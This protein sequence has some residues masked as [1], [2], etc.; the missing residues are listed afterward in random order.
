MHKLLIFIAVCSI[1]LITG[2]KYPSYNRYTYP[3]S[4]CKRFENRF[5]HV[6]VTFPGLVPL[7]AAIHL[8][9]NGQFDE[10]FSTAG[11]NNAAEVGVNFAMS[12]RFGIYTCVSRTVF[13]ATGFGFLYKTAGVEFLQENGATVIHD[14]EFR[15]GTN[16]Q[17]FTGVV[18]F[19]V[20]KNGVNPFTTKD[21]PVFVGPVGNVT[22]QLLPIARFFDLST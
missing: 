10:I 15:F 18:K 8:L 19:A 1:S 11:G 3:S 5:Y 12:H 13:R 4:S 21:A 16:D 14:Y 22:G 9:P 17:T 2:N 6:K 20:F 7:F